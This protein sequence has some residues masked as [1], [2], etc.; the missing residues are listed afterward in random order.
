M[1]VAFREDDIAASEVRSSEVR[2]KNLSELP[3][4]FGEG[5]YK[6][7][8][9]DDSGKLPSHVVSLD[10]AADLAYPSSYKERIDQ[11]P[12]DDGERGDWQGRRGESV[13]IPNK[14]DIEAVLG[15]YH[16]DGIRYKNGSPDFSPCSEATVEI[17]NM[18][19]NRNGPPVEGSNFQQCDQKCA[20]QWSQQYRDGICDWTA[21]NVADWRRENG[22]SWHERNDMKTCDLIPTK[23]NAYFGHLGGVG[24][25]IRLSGDRSGE[26]IFDE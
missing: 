16:I 12:K 24:E 6:A 5:R 19:E 21:R 20:E 2:A 18:T 11:T 3:D 15:K 7:E 14:D 26:G 13:F 8:L 4:D 25:C 22:Y 9:P 23:V 1:T 10:D 17:S